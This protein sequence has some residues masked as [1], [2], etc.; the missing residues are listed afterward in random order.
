MTRDSLEEISSRSQ[1]ALIRKVK[2]IVIDEISMVRSDVFNAIDL[3][4]RQ[5][6]D[7]YHRE[8][9]F[10]G[11]QIVLVGDLKKIISKVFEYFN[12]SAND[13]K[14]FCKVEKL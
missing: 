8:K 11:K 5:L 10:G 7:R 9:P 6:A 12:N 13:I 14:K 2:V 3:R 1:K 4:L